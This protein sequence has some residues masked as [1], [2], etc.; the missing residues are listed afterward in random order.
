[1]GQNAWH[2]L[3]LTRYDFPAPERVSSNLSM[4]SQARVVLINGWIFSG[5][6]TSLSGAQFA[7]NYTLSISVYH[8]RRSSTLFVNVFTAYGSSTCF[9]GFC[10]SPLTPYIMS[11]ANSD[12]GAGVHGGGHVL[13]QIFL[14]LQRVTKKKCLIPPIL[15]YW[16][17]NGSPPPPPPPNLKVAPRSLAKEFIRRCNR[18]F[19]GFKPDW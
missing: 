18:L 5:R 12:R 14:K 7:N 1:M 15:Q 4:L 3:Q 6:G 17:T 10:R 2:A 13:L 16:V 9:G 11:W 8:L 19:Q